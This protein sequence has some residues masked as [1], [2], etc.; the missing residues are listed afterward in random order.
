MS[1]VSQAGR[2]RRGKLSLQKRQM[3]AEDR[4][5]TWGALNFDGA[6]VRLHDPLR[7]REAQ[8]NP[9]KLARPGFIG[10]VKALENMRQILGPYADPGI[11]K[12]CYTGAIDL[13]ELNGN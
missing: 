13:R 6:S 4:T 9:T 7:Y 10:A 11:L 12:L 3:D 1:H 2:L 5:G 8:S